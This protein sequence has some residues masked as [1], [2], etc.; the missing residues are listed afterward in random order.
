M[1]VR[2]ERCLT[3][4][5]LGDDSVSEAGTSVQ[6]TTCGHTFR[7]RRSLAKA[8][9]SILAGPL[10]IA[11][12]VVEWRLHT[13]KGQVHRF[14]E[15]SVVHRWI[16]ERKVTRQDRISRPGEPWRQ[17][18]EIEELQPFFDIVDE[19]DRT[20]AALARA[21]E[22]LP[23]GLEPQAAPRRAA[24]PDPPPVSGVVASTPSFQPVPVAP[25]APEQQSARG[26]FGKM[27]ITLV[28]AAGVAYY[29]ISRLPP[30]KPAEGAPPL[31]FPTAVKG[32]DWAPLPAAPAPP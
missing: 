16:V 23:L 30:V 13:A 21:E 22:G 32:T 31:V 19:A 26:R 5:E 12:A 17:L 9:G 11:P 20:R 3:E 8:P 27:V 29:G 25:D 18:D 1:D 4:Y 10:A 7:V 15:L 6:C 24:E 14:L 28:V 2:C